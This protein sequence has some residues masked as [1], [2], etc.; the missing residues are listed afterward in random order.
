MVS[1]LWPVVA[2]M[3]LIQ[4]SSGFSYSA[5]TNGAGYS[6]AVSTSSD[7]LLVASTAIGGGGL[8]NTISGKGALH[9]NHFVANGAGATAQ[10]RAD[11]INADNYTYS[12]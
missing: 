12:L 11:L 7:E 10:V 1:H 6:E 3:I 5:S 2:L 9:E 4:S 8:S